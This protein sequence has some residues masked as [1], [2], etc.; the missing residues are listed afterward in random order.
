[1]VHSEYRS[2][3]PVG[4]GMS[5]FGEATAVRRTG[6]G[7]YSAVLD[8]DFGFEQALN[9]GYL[10]AVLARAALDAAGRPHPIST[11]ASFLRVAKPGPA[12]VLVETRKS[13]RTAEVARVSLVQDD[14]PI[15]DALITTGALDGD[16][17]PLYSEDAG[18]L[19]AIEE[20]VTFGGDGG[21]KD[22]FAAQ[23][24]MRYDPATMGWLDGRP[25]GRLEMRSHFRLREAYEPDGVLLALAVDAL[26]PVVLN[27]GRYGW[28]PTVELTWHMRAVPAPGPLA[29]YGSGRLVNDGWFDEE[30]E[31]R[32]TAGRLV[33]QSRQLARAGR[34]PS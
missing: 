2:N 14:T 27:T 32:D 13:G 12:E 1:M 31:V 20:C 30:V 24:D 8:A 23:I 17:E 22:G 3:F 21:G 7:R 34:R 11:A 6:E 29:L 9:G 18:H 28:S 25:S 33:A 15:V 5:G 26:P 16:A 19:P 4:A 10:M